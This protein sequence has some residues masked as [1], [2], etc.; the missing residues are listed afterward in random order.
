MIRQLTHGDLTQLP[1]LHATVWG[2]ED[3]TVEELQFVYRDL[4]PNL[5]IDHPWKDPKIHSLAH[6]ESS[7][8]I[9]GMIGIMTREMEFD[10]A[11]IQT[12]IS[13]NL[14]VDPQSRHQLPGVQLLKQFLNGP[15]DLSL[16]DMANRATVKIW[17]LLGGT[18]APLYSL[19]W[20]RPLRPSAF[21]AAI[22]RKRNRFGWA[23][24]CLKP[25]ISVL[26]HLAAKSAPKYFSQQTRHLRAEPLTPDVFLDRLPE[27]T[28]DDVLTPIYSKESLDWIWDRTHHLWDTGQVQRV[29][30]HSSQGLLLG[31]YIYNLI[32]NG[33]GEVA[34]IVATQRTV[35]QVIGHLFDHAVQHGAVGLS[36]RGQ[37]AFMQSLSDRGCV[38]H[39]RGKTVLVHSRRP[40]LLNAFQRPGVFLTSLEGEGCLS[41]YSRTHSV[42]QSQQS[43]ETL[44]PTATAAPSTQIESLRTTTDIKNSLSSNIDH[45]QTLVDEANQ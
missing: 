30:V 4:F 15:Q 36:G 24:S 9:S 5:F 43:T 29:S 1:Q 10:G 37:P 6:E 32:P 16:A 25:A 34:Q 2:T 28:A 23:L 38:F 26:D 33:I 8:R 27:F 41:L 42:N 11:S 13:S 18:T 21:C 31:W 12:A 7:G 22:L 35:N 14:C 44:R 45:V 40:E 39:R 20:V 19:N 3:Q 17:K